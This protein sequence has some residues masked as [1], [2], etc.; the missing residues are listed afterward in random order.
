MNPENL[1][2]A[3]IVVFILMSIGLVLT[4]MEFSR[5]AP[6]EQIDD[7]DKMQ[8]SPHGHVD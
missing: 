5:G 7:P 4:I 6:K 3:A 2:V 1:L 8:E